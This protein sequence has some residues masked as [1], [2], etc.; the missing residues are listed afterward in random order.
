[1]RDALAAVD[2]GEALDANAADWPKLRREL[3]AL[4]KKPDEQKPPPQQQKQPQQ[5]Q[6]QKNDSNQNQQNSSQNP[7]SGGKSPQDQAQQNQSSPSQKSDAA[8][9]QQ[10][11]QQNSPSSGSPQNQQTPGE[12]AF[13]DMK[14][15]SPTPAQPRSQPAE[16]RELQ[17]IGG[18]PEKRTG[19][20]A[21]DDP[22]LVVPMAKLDQLK[23]QDSP[24]VLYQLLR[25]ENAPPPTPNGKNW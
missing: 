15:K 7:S 20:A 23:Q 14:E 12:P 17:K 13:G 6:S 8:K 21:T 11:S 16:A 4:K 9:N 5:Q 19:D 10:N 18:A 24:A 25:G 22:A 3:A 2:A 1:V